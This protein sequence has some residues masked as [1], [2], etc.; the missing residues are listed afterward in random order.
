MLRIIISGTLHLLQLISDASCLTE[1][2]VKFNEPSQDLVTDVAKYIRTV[3]SKLVS[4]SFQ[5]FPRL[6]AAVMAVVC[7]QPSTESHI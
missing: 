3:L 7:R 1:I 6:L 2:W 5:E 4:E